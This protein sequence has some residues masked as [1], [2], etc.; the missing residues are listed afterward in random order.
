MDLVCRGPQEITICH[1]DATVVVISL[2]LAVVIVCYC[3]SVVVV[4]AWWWLLL[5]LL[6]LWLRALLSIL[7]SSSNSRG[8]ELRST[9]RRARAARGAGSKGLPKG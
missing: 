2:L 6:L 8:F 7:R 3:S 1:L 4:I 5:L 9:F